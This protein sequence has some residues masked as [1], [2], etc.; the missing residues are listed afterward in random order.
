VKGAEV[1]FAFDPR[2]L[3]TSARGL[4]LDSGSEAGMTINKH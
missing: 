3:N 2:R 4:F 1:L